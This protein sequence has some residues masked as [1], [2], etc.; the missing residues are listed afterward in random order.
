MQDIVE[1]IIIAIKPQYDSS[2]LSAG[3]SKCI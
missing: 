3:D 1:N 2:V